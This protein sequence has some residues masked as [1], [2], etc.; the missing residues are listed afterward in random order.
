[1]KNSD[2]EVLGKVAFLLG[3]YLPTAEYDLF[4]EYL[5]IY[6]W[7]KTKNDKEKQRY[8]DKAEYHREATK[9]WRQENA[10]KNRDYQRN[11]NKNKRIE[12]NRA[13][14]R[15]SSKET[16]FKENAE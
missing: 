11:Y 13:K 1:M 8:N 7:L 3:K 12:E 10:D 16:G 14:L 6:E 9:K 5:R 2:I 15:K 4:K